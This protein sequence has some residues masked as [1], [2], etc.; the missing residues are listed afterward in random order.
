MYREDDESLQRI[1]E[2]HWNRSSST[3]SEFKDDGIRRCH[4]YINKSNSAYSI[5]GEGIFSVLV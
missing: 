1:E 3:R 2:Q 5:A 4:E